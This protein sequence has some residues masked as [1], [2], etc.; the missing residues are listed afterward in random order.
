MACSANCRPFVLG[1]YV[2]RIR[3][4]ECGATAIEY[5]FIGALIIIVVVASFT[6]LG[7]SSNGLWSNVN[8]KV[9]SKL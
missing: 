9:S 8:S 3:K 7:S 5:A 4:D 1:G 6:I 2:K